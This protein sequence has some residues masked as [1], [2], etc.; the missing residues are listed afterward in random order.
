M[1]NKTQ[2]VFLNLGTPNRTSE[3][4]TVAYFP[5]ENRTAFNLGGKIVNFKEITGANMMQYP[6]AK[7]SEYRNLLVDIIVSGEKNVQVL[8]KQ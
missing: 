8:N 1:S 4:Q 5:K 7:K 2:V 3:L 6:Q